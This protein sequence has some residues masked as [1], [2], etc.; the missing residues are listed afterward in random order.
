MDGV[1]KS[2]DGSKHITDERINTIT[3]LVGSMLSIL[4]TSVM[5]QR[6]LVSEWRWYELAAMAVYGLGLINL[7]VMSTL[8]HGLRVGQ[9]AESVLRTLDYL[10]IFWL[11]AGTVTA[12]V[13]YALPNATGIAVLAATWTLAVTGIALKASIPK[14]ERHITNTLFIALG[15]LPASL[16][17]ILEGSRFSLGEM[18]A[19][20]AG[21]LLYSVGFVIYVTE[22]PNPRPGLFGFH[23]IWHILVV[24]ASQIHAILIVSMIQ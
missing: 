9:R 11:I 8:H 24:V 4:L 20:A 23:E 19:L 14:L 6:V 15:W 3:S 21:G 18:L 2:R 1:V 13:A 17:I 10:A 5:L 16:L 22:R 12:T 7:F